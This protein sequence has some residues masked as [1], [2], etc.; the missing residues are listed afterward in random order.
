MLQSA[1]VGAVAR[2]KPGSMRLSGGRDLGV[3]VTNWPSERPAACR[4]RSKV[5][6]SLAFESENASGEVF[7]KHFFC[8]SQQVVAPLA[9]GEQF[10]TVKDFRFRD[11]GG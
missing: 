8:G 5:A 7:R 4:N 1:K 3:R 10:D 9:F 6:C 11:R 2:C